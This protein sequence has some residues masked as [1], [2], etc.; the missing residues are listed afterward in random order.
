M[1][2]HRRW[3]A[4]LVAL[5]AASVLLWLHPQRA[6]AAYPHTVLSG[7]TLSGIAAANGMSTDTLAAFNGVSADSY[8][9]TGQTVNIP[10]STELATTS[11]TT[12]APSTT[13]NST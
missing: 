3:P 13:A 2:R 8:V 6:L 12:S 1:L 10:S 5:A 9:Y 11:P 4:A 7:E